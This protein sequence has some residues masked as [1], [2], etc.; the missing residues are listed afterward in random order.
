MQGHWPQDEWLTD[1]AFD[2]VDALTAFAQERGLSLLEVAIGGLAS[3]PGVGSVIAG[4][5]RPEQVLAN[6]RGAQWVPTDEDLEQLRALGRS[7]VAD[8]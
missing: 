7:A 4:A 6:A 1:E 3:M 2:R 8:A 5:T